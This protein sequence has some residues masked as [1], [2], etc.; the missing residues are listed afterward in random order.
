M[1]KMFIFSIEAVQLQHMMHPLPAE[2]VRSNCT[3]FSA[4]PYQLN[5][6]ILLVA[7][8]R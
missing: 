3:V 6:E 5:T 8:T 1:V 7:N 2:S 4:K